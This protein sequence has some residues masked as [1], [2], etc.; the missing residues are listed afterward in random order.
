MRADQGKDI[1][2]IP[3][4]GRSRTGEILKRIDGVKTRRDGDMTIRMHI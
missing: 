3:V 1:G 2:D 4:D